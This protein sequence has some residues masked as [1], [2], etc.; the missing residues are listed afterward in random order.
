LELQANVDETERQ[1]ALSTLGY[2]ASWWQYGFVSDA[3]L[4]AQL[5]RWRIGADTNAEHY[6]YAAFLSLLTGRDALDDLALTRIVELVDRDPDRTM[7]QAVLIQF[8]RWPGLTAGQRSWL[9]DQPACAAPVVQ[10]AF[11]R[12]P[13]RRP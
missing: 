5:A 4:Q 8:A 13:Q 11:E 1:V 9:R 10:R 3:T 7:G 2:D 6:R 12:P